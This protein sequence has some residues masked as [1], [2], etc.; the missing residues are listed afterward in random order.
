M[1]KPI[2]KSS[3]R[4]LALVVGLIV[5][6]VAI[7]A[8]L[9][10]IILKQ[11]NR[12]LDTAM[13]D[14]QGHIKDFDLALWKGTYYIEGL[15][16]RKRSA[17][18]G[19]NL[20]EIKNIEVDVS[21]AALFRGHLFLDVQLWEPVITL[22][23]SAKPEAKQQGTEEKNWTQV[24]DSLIPFKIQSV[25]VH[26]GTFRF[27][28][29]DLSPP[30]EVN[31]DRI[32][33]QLTNI[34]NIHSEN[35]QKLPSKLNVDARL[36]KQ[37]DVSLKGRLR[38]AQEPWAARL[39]LDL[40]PFPLASLNDFF[41]SYGFFDLTEGSIHGQA[42]LYTTWPEVD[43]LIQVRGDKIDVVAPRQRFLGFRGVITEIGLALVNWF[44][45]NKDQE[46]ST[47]LKIDG[48]WPDLKLDTWRAV[49]ELFK[50]DD[51]KAQ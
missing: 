11:L 38:L 34:G 41:R 15:W 31:L 21:W 24:L 32:G 5:I 49:R 47:E 20:I 4:A 26:D 27:R 48:S 2:S 10:G 46:I 25:Q 19:Q 8:A 45:Q 40:A 17:P 28:R 13:T 51:E 18:A 7:R 37:S 50:D 14:Y 43:A 30:V 35:E 33:L 9:P 6:L 42:R 23:D 1:K 16:L 39:R 44:V 3:R 12:T 36:Q 29:S 22:Y